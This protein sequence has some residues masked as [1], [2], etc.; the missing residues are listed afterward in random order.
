MATKSVIITT[1]LI[2]LSIISIS[3]KTEKYILI[4]S[5]KGRGYEVDKGTLIKIQTD[6]TDYSGSLQNVDDN[7]IVVD[8]I[9]Y[10]WNDINTL[11][12]EDKSIFQMWTKVSLLTFVSNTILTIFGVA[13]DNGDGFLG[14]FFAI[15]TIPMLLLS[16]LFLAI[17]AI[18]MKKGR[19]IKYKK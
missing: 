2:L 19:T 7:G 17:G 13:T 12:F 8:S 10:N 9:F 15:I 5:A 18:F 6:S 1:F 3:Q 11:N 4:D 14:L 16:A